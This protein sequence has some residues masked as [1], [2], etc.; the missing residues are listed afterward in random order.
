VSGHLRERTPGSWELR[1]YQGRDPLTR[2]K[3]Y[4]TRT[5]KGTRREANKALAQFV[6]QTATAT[7]AT[8]GTFGELAERWYAIAAPDWAPN[9]RKEHRRIIDRYLPPITAIRLERLRT[10]DLDSFYS[11]LR[12]HGGTDGRP[13]A[14]ATVHRIHVVVRRAL[15]QGV[16]WEWIGSNPAAKASPGRVDQAEIVPPDPQDVIALL[17]L[18]EAQDPDL[19]FFL[20]LAALTGARRGE[21]CALRWSDFDDDAVTFARVIAIGTDGPVEVPKRSRNK[22]RPRTVA[23]DFATSL[24]VSAHR[25]RCAERSLA[26]GRPLHA[27]AFVFSHEADGSRPWRPDSTSRRFRH[28]RAGVDLDTMR[29]H[30]L[31][32][33]VVTTLMAAGVDLTT[34]AGRVGHA[35]GGRTT[36]AVY[37][38]FRK[39]PDR[40]A[41][42]LLANILGRTS[43]DGAASRTVAGLPA[44]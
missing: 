28:L 20:L 23:I 16:R 39:P 40:A 7:V 25:A 41:A 34:I 6:A 8:Q 26:C 14:P 37:A 44:G 13:L 29:L 21:M 12:R 30:D 5:F 15:E 2:R 42:E 31:R 43:G 33:F 3:K 10:A 17:A 22:G 1:A 4:A 35:D 36:Q 11:S 24:V 27:D 32:H 38:H 19:A 9:T 18:A